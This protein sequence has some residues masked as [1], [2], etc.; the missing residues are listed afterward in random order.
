MNFTITTIPQSLESYLAP[1]FPGVTFFREPCPGACPA[2]AM[3]LH[4]KSAR[5]DQGQGGRWLR[6]VGLELTY[7]AQ[8]P[9]L[10]EQ[11]LQAA[12][13]LDLALTSFPYSDGDQTQLLRTCGREWNIDLDALYYRFALQVWTHPNQSSQ[14]M[15]SMGYQPEV[16]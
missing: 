7:L 15:E 10:Q 5:V 11:Y 4:L 12:Q 3:F 9:N 14:P 16:R 8:G 6:Q 2:P 13:T 1:L